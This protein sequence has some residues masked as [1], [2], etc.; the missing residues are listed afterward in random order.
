M[1]PSRTAITQSI[2]KLQE[3]RSSPLEVPPLYWQS[4]L[5]S[6]EG[7]PLTALTP[8][9]A[10]SREGNSHYFRLELDLDA[11]ARIVSLE[12]FY[13]PRESWES[14][15]PPP[16]D[17]RRC[18]LVDGNQTTPST[19]RRL[20]SHMRRASCSLLKIPKG[21]SSIA[22]VD[23]P[24]S[25]L[26]DALRALFGWM[27]WRAG[28]AEFEAGGRGRA[29]Y[30]TLV[31]VTS[32]PGWA[33]GHLFRA[34]GNDATVAGAFSLDLRVAC[35]PEW[36]EAHPMLELRLPGSP[37]RPAPWSTTEKELRHFGMSLRGDRIDLQYP[38][39][40]PLQSLLPADGSLDALVKLVGRLNDAPVPTPR[41]MESM[42]KCYATRGLAKAQDMVEAMLRRKQPGLSPRVAPEL[43]R[44]CEFMW[45]YSLCD[46]DE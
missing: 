8:T 3:S 33:L 45:R 9:T 44:V 43:A 32:L 30:S 38:I 35:V 1:R 22:P 6:R 4:D 25:P 41:S 16:P 46:I 14:G 10:L 20:A 2:V 15:R 34:K 42:I 27:V 40:T 28:M 21:L 29:D 17:E 36:V 11:N 5:Q 37:L 18:F 13:W 26:E 24:V 7:S 12:T 19:R 39:A 31:L 23:Q